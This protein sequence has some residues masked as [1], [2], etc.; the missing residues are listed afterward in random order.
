MKLGFVVFLILIYFL[1]SG[2]AQN[3]NNI[4]QKLNI[5]VI[6]CL[7]STNLDIKSMFKIKMFTDHPIVA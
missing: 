6:K 2:F 5:A 1:P 7:L 3:S 4:L